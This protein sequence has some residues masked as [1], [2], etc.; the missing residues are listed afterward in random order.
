MP[1]PRL[2][3]RHLQMIRAIGRT[4]R[5]VDAAEELGLTASALSHRIKEAERRLGVPLFERLHKRLRMTAAAEYLA[6][7][8]ERLLRDLELVE[9]DV[10]RMNAG[11]EHVVRLTVEA[12]SA[13]HWLPE[14]LTSFE[15]DHSHISIQVMAGAGKD[16]L[17]ALMNRE[18]DLVIC[19]G[20]TD[21]TGIRS[22]PL[23]EDP[24]V[25]ICSPTHDLA[26][27]DFVTA[28]DFDKLTFITYPKIP[29]PDREF[30]KLFRVG[31]R[32]PSWTA[33]V[34]LPEAIVELVAA[35][36]GTSVLAN[37]A[38]R[39]HVEAGRLHAA[40]LGE[41]GINI[42]WKIA[43][44]EEETANSHTTL[45]ANQIADWFHRNHTD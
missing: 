44:R 25:F 4:G 12:Y 39:P 29:E 2:D 27:R 20:E 3:I 5:I 37:W 40:R 31:D 34:E 36:Q 7:V 33:T 35:S 19:S 24:L 9:S 1:G 13:Y 45:T 14:F 8:S 22:I 28:D 11:I 42:P 18:V 41:D 26:T 16:P 17:Q 38:V 32:Y 23:F 10:R 15:Q 6:D 43:F 21:P 30:A